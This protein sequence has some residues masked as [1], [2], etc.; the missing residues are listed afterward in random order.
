MVESNNNCP[1]AIKVRGLTKTYGPQLV[2]RGLNLELAWG[3]FLI[4]FGPNG[5]GKTT[6]VKILAT[7]TKPSNGE[8]VV[9]GFDLKR[10]PSAI[11][12]NI[13][14][15]THQPFLYPELTARENLQFQGK[16]FTLTGLE[17]RIENIADRIG[18]HSFLERRVSILSHG[19]Q[20]RF[21]L[22]RA[23]LHDPPILL[24]DEPETGL[25]QEALDMLGN[26][27]S[28]GEKGRRTVLMTTH[29]LERGLALGNRVAILAGGRIAFHEERD[30]IDEAMFKGIYGKFTGAIS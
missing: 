10:N 1:L 6:L 21:S 18:V 4:I 11:R 14:L 30:S 3:D 5:S 17:E 26:V 19:I 24:L 20:K 7:V 8:V 13:G 22:A 2:I 23:I 28:I 25:D 16:M 27:M 12:R 29:S 15:V 9:A